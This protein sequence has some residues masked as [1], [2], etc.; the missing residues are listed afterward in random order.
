[1]GEMSVR[2]EFL[3]E[4]SLGEEYTGE[5]SVQEEFLGE[6]SL[7]EKYTGEM[8][9]QEEFLGEGVKSKWVKCL[10]KKSFCAVNV[11]YRGSE[12]PVREPEFGK[13]SM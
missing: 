3:G 12:I 7:G 9:V 10:C 4:E 1:M 8:F 6:E 13:K 5:M 2:E 11:H